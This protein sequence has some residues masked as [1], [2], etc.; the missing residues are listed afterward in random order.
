MAAAEPTLTMSPDPQIDLPVQRRARRVRR[1][2]RRPRP[3]RQGPD[4]RLPR[5]VRGARPAGR[6]PRGLGR[7]QPGARPLPV[8]AADAGVAT[9]QGPALGQPRHA[10]RRSTSAAGSSPCASGWWTSSRGSCAPPRSRWA[11]RAARSWR[12]AWRRAASGC[13]PPSRG[14]LPDD[15][16]GLRLLLDVKGPI[17]RMDELGKDLA[18][19][20]APAGRRVGRLATR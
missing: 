18:P 5:V 9:T 2:Q 6:R 19:D 8:R 10:L 12:S 16:L 4:A 11:S 3:R 20:R 15:Y 14:Q 7:G 13:P 17:E 1:P